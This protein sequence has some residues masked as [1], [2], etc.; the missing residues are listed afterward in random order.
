[1]KTEVGLWIDHRH[2]VIVSVVGHA[3]NIQRVSAN[4]HHRQSGTS[5][6]A[7]D[8]RQREH[9]NTYCEEVVS[10]IRTAEAI[11]IFG[12]GEAKGELNARLEKDKLGGRVVGI[13]T[14]DKMSDPQIVAK[15]RGHYLDQ[16]AT[17]SSPKPVAGPPR[18]REGKGGSAVPVYE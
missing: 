4:E 12:P 5:G 2:A 18:P 1:M 17:S 8:A 16:W 3:E 11:L 6:S 15:V 7:D 14:S 10:R 13:E 9:R